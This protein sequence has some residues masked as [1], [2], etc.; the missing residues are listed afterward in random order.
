M[1]LNL[2]RIVPFQKLSGVENMSLD[3]TLQESVDRQ[4][5]PTL[6]FYGWNVPTLSLG[7]FQPFLSRRTHSPSLLSA[8]VRRATG[9]G[10][11]MHHRELTYSLVLP[12]SIQMIGPRLDLYEKI[13]AS[14]VRALY[15]CGV[16]VA[17]FRQSDQN[18][19]GW[20]CDAFLCFR[21]RTAEDL[22]L[23]G[24]KV[25]GSAQRKSR[26]S[27]LQHGSLLLDASEFA[28]ELPGVNDLLNSKV[29]LN[30]LIEAITQNFSDD[31]GIKWKESSF[32][33]E[34]MTRANEIAADRFA[35]ERWL[36]RR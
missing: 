32:S 26:S 18:Q 34:E 20:D 25:L 1:T 5:I 30:E 21:R 7:Y 15:D 24:Y 27:L 10:A 16:P 11:I 22:I 35:S 12:Q 31:L 36:C 14:L 33:S 23:H 9:G 3:Q 28:P 8:C 6:R 19:C 13:H 2:G 17:P 29:Q 4:Q